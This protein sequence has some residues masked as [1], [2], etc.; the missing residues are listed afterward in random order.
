[1]G[2]NCRQTQFLLDSG[3]TVVSDWR[4]RGSR[5][6]RQTQFLS[7]SGSTVVP[8]ALSSGSVGSPFIHVVK[9]FL[10]R[11]QFGYLPE[12]HFDGKFLLDQIH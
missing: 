3:G 2:R 9:D 5:G 6:C 12:I 10:K 8:F 7:G 11:G 1:M 4:K